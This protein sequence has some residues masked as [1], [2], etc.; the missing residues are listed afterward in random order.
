MKTKKICHLTSVHPRYDS[1]ILHRECVSLAENGYEVYLLVNDNGQKE[2]YHG[3]KIFTTH[4]YYNNRIKR[5]CFGVKKIYDL[6]KKVDAEIYHLHDPEL[7]LIAPFLKRKG[8]K[9]VFDSHETYYLQI[10]EKEYIPLAFRKMLAGL[11]WLIETVIIKKIDAVIC[12]GTVLGKNPFKGRT[13]RVAYIN[14]VPRLEELEV[15]I[16]DVNKKEENAICYVGSLTVDR[17]ITNLVKAAYQANVTLYLAGKFSPA[18]Y[19]QEL[20]EMEEYKAVKYLGFL[21]RREIYDLYSKVCIGMCTLLPV[22]QYNKGDNLPT[23][24]YEYM[25]AGLPVILSDF[26]YNKKV[27]EK[28][29]FGEIVNPEDID[30]ITNKIKKML[31]DKFLCDEA[32]K[33]GRE[34]VLKKYNWSVEE[35]KLLGLYEVLMRK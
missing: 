34:I 10:R 19:E 15:E 5:M 11:Y 1:R 27:M 13:K 32:G 14:N 28:Y 33:K 8:K 31:S 2:N 7:L 9:V 26:P 17:G 6:A 24:V 22:G 23:K 21:D 18:A 12:P 4:R 29:Q 20:M 25:A 3:V 30:E 16:T 35:K